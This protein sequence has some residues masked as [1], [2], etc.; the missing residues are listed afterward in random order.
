MNISSGTN[1]SESPKCGKRSI[2]DIFLSLLFVLIGTILA[3]G[4][5]HFM[6]Q[7]ISGILIVLFIIFCIRGFRHTILSEFILGSFVLLMLLLCLP[8]DFALRDGS[9]WSIDIAEVQNLH[10]IWVDDFGAI[11]PAS[12]PT[13]C[14][15]IIYKGNSLFVSVRWALLV[16]VPVELDLYTPLFQ[17][18]RTPFL[19]GSRK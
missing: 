12:A 17:N 9:N 11:L 8:F 15:T 1:R 5:N 10:D 14:P 2:L 18:G 6:A 3:A 4:S 7:L 19:I 16:T 13:I